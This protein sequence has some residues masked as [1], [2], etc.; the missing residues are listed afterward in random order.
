VHPADLNSGEK[1]RVEFSTSSSTE[2]LEF[3][4]VIFATDAMTAASVVRDESHAAVLREYKYVSA[5]V[6]I[7]RSPKLMPHHKSDWSPM[8][9][10]TRSDLSES[11]FTMWLS[12]PRVLGF[13]PA[14]DLIH[15]DIFQTWNPFL[16]VLTPAERADKS[17]V[18][19][20]FTTIRSLV[21]PETRSTCERLEGLQG[22][23]GVY[24]VGAYVNYE[25]PLLENAVKSAAKVRQHKHIHTNMRKHTHI[26]TYI[27]T[28]LCTN[29]HTHTHTHTHTYTTHTYITHMHIH[30]HTHTHTHTQTHTHIIKTYMYTHTKASTRAHTHTKASTRARTHTHTHTRTQ[31][32]TGSKAIG[33]HA[34]LGDQIAR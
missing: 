20:E 6:A 21:T 33:S 30:K 22:H 7:H 26:S 12:H 15:G 17:V 25:V 3:D 11:M 29:T 16:D 34:G 32:H 28:L 18:I 31:T 23:G 1:A 8:N 4:A 24:Y 2:T 5:P 27:H 10:V 19:S 9:M 13:I 14:S